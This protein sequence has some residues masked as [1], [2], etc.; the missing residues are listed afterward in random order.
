MTPNMPDLTEDELKALDEAIAKSEA[1][2]FYDGDL[3][4]KATRLY[5][6]QRRDGG[7]LPIESAPKDGT[8]I[9]LALTGGKQCVARTEHNPFQGAQWVIYGELGHV[10]CWVL[11]DDCD[12][13]H[14]QPLPK[15]PEAK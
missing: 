5:A 1:G 7:W 11:A 15:P 3:L 13:T 4:I 9:L 10:G 12:P 2:E 6:D 8:R 14:W